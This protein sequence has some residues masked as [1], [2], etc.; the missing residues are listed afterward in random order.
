MHSI[1]GCYESVH[2][3][4]NGGPSAKRWREHIRKHWSIPVR[5]AHTDWVSAI[6]NNPIENVIC[7]LPSARKTGCFQDPSVPDNRLPLSKPYSSLHSSTD[8]IQLCSSPIHSSNSPSS[9]IIVSM[10]SCHLHQYLFNHLIKKNNR[11]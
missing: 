11:W 6:D 3:P 7:S 4:A 1:I 2:K 9:R 8:R 10:N 5:Y